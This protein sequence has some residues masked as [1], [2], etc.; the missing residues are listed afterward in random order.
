MKAARAFL[1]MVVIVSFALVAVPVASSAA[2]MPQGAAND[3]WDVYSGVVTAGQAATLRSRFDHDVLGEAEAKKDGHVRV[4]VILNKRLVSDLEREGIHLKLH[5]DKNGRTVT[6]AASAKVAKGDTV[7]RKYLGSGGHKQDMQSLASKYPGITKLVTI[8]TS[9]QG[10]PI[11]AI[12]VTR[13]ARTTTD[14]SRPA[15]LYIG[16]QHAREWISPAVVSR[17]MHHFV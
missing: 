4:A 5:K 14:G 11:N 7:F 1:V 15:V 10:T 17:L 9:H 6:Q 16:T 8:G 13:N 2:G 3:V 12:K